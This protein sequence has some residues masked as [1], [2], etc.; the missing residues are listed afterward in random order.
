MKPATWNSGLKW[1]DPNLRYGSPSVLL[2]PGDPGYV[3]PVP[4]L[5]PQTK[6]KHKK[7]TMSADYIPQSYGN[8]EAWLTK[9]TNVLTAVLAAA[10]D[11]SV[12]ERAAFLAAIGVLLPAVSEIVS[13]QLQL[14]AKTAGFQEIL[15]A[16]VPIIRATIKRGKTSPHCTAEIQTNLDWVAHAPN[17]D[18]E[19]SRP[20]IL[21]EPQRARVKISGRKPGFEA[22]SLYSRIKGQVQWKLIAVR[23]RKF[24]YYDESPLAVA[25][26][27]EVREYM[28]IGVVNDEEVGQ[29]SE[30]IEVVYA[31]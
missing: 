22:V 10:M 28:A 4:P 26:A 14:E 2:E 29:P 3:A 27:P 12:A 6:P 5:S 19:H 21:V 13:L 15:D 25:G 20:F 24:P 11:M 23:K 16:Q 31:G 30:I 18:P 1:G 7:N 17:L 8:L 9:Q